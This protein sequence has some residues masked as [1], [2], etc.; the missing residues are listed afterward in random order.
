MKIF[1]RFLILG[2]SSFFIVLFLFLTS[3]GE[4]KKYCIY[5][6]YDLRYQYILTHISKQSILFRL[7]YDISDP[8]NV[9]WM[10]TNR[11][12]L[13]SLILIVGYKIDTA[14]SQSGS[15]GYSYRLDGDCQYCDYYKTI[16]QYNICEPHEY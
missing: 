15:N 11:N 14:L 16:T 10:S 2:R 8:Y 4:K 9:K 3:S 6:R 12:E 1:S 13:D 7:E 5:R